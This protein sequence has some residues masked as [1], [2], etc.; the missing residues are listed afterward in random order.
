MKKRTIRVLWIL[1][2]AALFMVAYLLFWSYTGIGF[3]CPV[4]RLSGLDCPGCGIT[5]ALLS[6]LK[7]D[8]AAMLSANL[9]S[10]LI[11]LYAAYVFFYVAIVYIR[12]GKYEVM[13]KPAFLGV[14]FLILFVTWGV[15][16]N[17]SS[18]QS[19]L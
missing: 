18:F 5:R 11:V 17:L 6:L 7:L 19:F 8:F 15:I 13:P 4:K 1:L 14:V 3:F 2:G 9:F 12:T 16:R 10:P